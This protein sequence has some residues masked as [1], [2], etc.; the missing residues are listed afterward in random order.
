MNEFR[1]DARTA[2]LGILLIAL[3]GCGG[4]PLCA[5]SADCARG[6]VC[7][8]SGRCG[9][10]RT[11]EG[12]RFAASRWLSPSDWGVTRAVR[13]SDTIP[14]GGGAETLFTFGPMPEPS[15]ILR[16]LLILH[17]AEPRAPLTTSAQILVERIGAFRGGVLPARSSVPPTAFATARRQL[18]PGPAPIVRLD[19]TEAAR[20]AD[21]GSLHL[22]VRADS[23]TPLRFASPFASDLGSRPRIE[24]MVR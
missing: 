7:G 9:R 18:R 20:A 6:S 14:L 1:F 17:P 4:A 23:D 5:G 3:G 16:A 10:L 12:S 19:V 11:P 13:L 2:Q 21:A 15:A 22:L 8:V 24:L